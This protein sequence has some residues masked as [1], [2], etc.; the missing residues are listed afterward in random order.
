[1]I[2]L[3]NTSNQESSI[4]LYVFL[5]ILAV[6]LFLIIFFSARNSSLN[7]KVNVTSSY[8]KK[9]REIN[10][11]TSFKTISRSSE[12]KTFYLNS[13]RAYDNFDLYKRKAEFIR[14]N[15]SYYEQ[16]VSNI[17]YNIETLNNYNKQIKD[18]PLTNDEAFA[19]SNKMSL[20]S[21][22]KRETKLGAKLLKHP[23]TSYSLRIKWEYTSPA[24]RNHYYN[25]R[26]FGFSDIKSAVS[27]FRVTSSFTSRSQ[28]SRSNSY[29]QPRY[30]QPSP[31][32]YTN[33]D[34]EDID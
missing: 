9:I 8:I 28:E 34:I 29:T 22:Q 23:C 11:S 33:D 17:N 24:G 2:I 4:G 20:K 26:D 7:K 30:Q 6:G 25:Y 32:V 10:E 12:T 19:K 31:K 18:I 15:L 14:D 13:K 16:L 1:M 3:T 27:Q 5:G 21:Y